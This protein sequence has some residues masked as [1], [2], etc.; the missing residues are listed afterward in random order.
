M[1]QLLGIM[2]Q[3]GFLKPTCAGDVPKGVLQQANAKCSKT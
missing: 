2:K 3:G 1:K